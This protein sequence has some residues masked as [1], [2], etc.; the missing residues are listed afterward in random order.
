MHSFKGLVSFSFS[1][2]VLV[3]VKINYN[4]NLKYEKEK[5]LEKVKMIFASHMNYRK[6]ISRNYLQLTFI[7]N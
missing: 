4:H 3:K 1:E 7:Y 2:N 6:I 5:I